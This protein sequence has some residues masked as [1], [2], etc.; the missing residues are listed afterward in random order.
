MG[1][2]RVAT[3][4]MD[5]RGGDRVA[6][7]GGRQAV[8]SGEVGGRQRPDEW[9]GWDTKLGGGCGEESSSAPGGKQWRDPLVERL[10]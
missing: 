4:E 6:A 2:W 9:G 10:G 3:R 7:A 1:S 5:G 8:G